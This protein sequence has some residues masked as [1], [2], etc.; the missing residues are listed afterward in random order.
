MRIASGRHRCLSDEPAK[1]EYYLWR[2]MIDARYQRHGF[3]RQAIG[4]LVDH[5]RA[6]PAAT[7][8]L[9]SC[10]PGEGSPRPFY[11]GLGFT[12]TGRDDDGEQELRLAL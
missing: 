6:R 12:Y 5:V 2:F 10:V 9:T 7:E 4:L 8:L 3:G 1:P 11:E